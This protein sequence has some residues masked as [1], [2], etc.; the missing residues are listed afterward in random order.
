MN[1]VVYWYIVARVDVLSIGE[2]NNKLVQ[3]RA[4]NTEIHI[5]SYTNFLD[6]MGFALPHITI[7][8]KNCFL[9][10][11]RASNAEIQISSYKCTNLL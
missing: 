6:I 7:F 2:G 5:F 9:E 11:L 3:L 8:L 1:Q 10:Q 4:S